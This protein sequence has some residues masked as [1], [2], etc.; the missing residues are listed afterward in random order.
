[1]SDQL[2]LRDDSHSFYFIFF[3]KSCYQPNFVS[4]LMVFVFVVNYSACLIIIIVVVII[5][6]IIDN[7]KC[8]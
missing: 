7:E 6:I 3:K 5:I 4:L 1:M 8:K 2:V